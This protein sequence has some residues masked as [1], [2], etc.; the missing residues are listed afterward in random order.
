MQREALFYSKLEENK[1]K[2]ELCPVGC[3]ISP[4]NKGVCIG[5]KNM[6]GKLVAVNYGQAVSTAM[7]PIEKKP[8]YHFYPGSKI[9]STGP[10]GCNLKCRNC[11]NWAISQ[12]EVYADFFSS[13]DM[14]NI[15]LKNCSIGI[16]YTYT[17]PL[18]WYEYVFDT[19]KL[20][21]EA[22]MVNV[23][24]TNGYVN[25]QPL[26]NLLPL[27]DAMNIDLKSMDDNFY[28][29]V[30]KGKVEPVL[31]TI[32][33]VFEAGCHLEITNLVIPG[34]NDSE[35][36]IRKLVDWIAQLGDK[37]PLHFSRYFPEYKMNTPPTSITTL[38]KAYEIG[39][40]KL[41]YVYVGNA[42][43]HEASNTHCPACANLLIRRERYLTEVLGVENKKCKMCG[44]PIDII[45]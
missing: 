24:V 22:G 27:I 5:R 29:E 36:Q 42:Y 19:A 28:K 26:E 23:L 1:I 31:K 14:V 13:E 3:I 40:E 10:N 7:D 43:M 30:C 4:G 34:L 35:E 18:I 15:A 38:T 6:E 21:R 32:Q 25:P 12:E 41:K 2:C 20:V 9:F 33:T 37:I 17:E 16:A 8:L 39:R 44:S 45:M 11:Q